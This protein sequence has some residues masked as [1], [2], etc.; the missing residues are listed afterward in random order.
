MTDLI[1][2]A[3]QAVQVS[4]L[5]GIFFRLGALTAAHKGFSERIERIERRIFGGAS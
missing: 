2:T 1:S 3:F 4:V 5:T